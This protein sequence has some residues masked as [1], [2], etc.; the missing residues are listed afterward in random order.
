MTK[1]SSACSDPESRAGSNCLWIAGLLAL[2]LTSGVEAQSSSCNR[3]RRIVKE[4]EAMPA[5]T[6]ADHRARLARLRAAQSLCSS[7]GDLWRV[8]HCSA[9]ALKDPGKAEF[10]KK[11]AVLNGIDSLICGGA[12]SPGLPQQ[13]PLSPY[14]RRKFALVIGI[15]QFED[16]KIPSLRYTAKDARDFADVLVRHA[17]FK[18]ANVELLVE[19]E[20]TRANILN[21]LQRLILTAEEEDL[22]VLYI[23]SH[24]SPNK[25]QGLQGIGYIV[26]HDTF[27]KRIWVD[28]IEYQD[29]ARKAALIKARRMVTFLDTC[30]SGQAFHVTGAKQLAAEGVGVG[31]DTAKLFISGEGTYVITSSRF[32]EQSWES[33]RLANSYFTYFL[34]EALRR[35]P[36]PRSIREI[37]DELA[38]E[39]TRVVARDQGVGQHPQIH[40]SDEKADVRIGVAPI[41]SSDTRIQ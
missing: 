34:L 6:T 28:A 17:H 32:D 19:E 21:G 8:A 25:G 7:L 16:P 26:T 41:S 23:S 29:F 20:A 14:V 9:R 30:F 37:F 27:L 35:E 18:P 22:V 1:D 31:S 36:D 40:P 12:S 2:V 13:P 5:A 3:A 4:V 38:F 24:G 15:G 10:Y 11:Q 33:E 39:V